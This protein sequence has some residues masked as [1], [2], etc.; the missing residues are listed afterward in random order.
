MDEGLSE[1][2][3]RSR[4]AP[5]SALGR[6]TWRV[7]L[8]HR[9]QR[10]L[11]S[12]TTVLTTLALLVGVGAGL[13][14][15]GFIRLIGLCENLL[16]G[17]L[18]DLLNGMQNYALIVIPVVGALPVGL[19]ITRIASE[20]KG[21]G[22][23]EVMEA[24]ALR[25][26]RIRPVVVVA[27]AVASALCIG[28]GGSVGREGPIVQIGAALGS[29]FGQWF[30]LSDLRM[31]TLVACGA[32]AGIASTFNAPIAGVFFALELILGEFSMGAFG[33]VVLSSV[34]ASVTSRFFLQDHPAFLR[35]P[36]YALV[37]PLV[38]LP[39]Y[40]LLGLLMAAGATAF[41]K[42]LYGMEG[43]F[44]RWSF[45]NWLKPAVGGLLLGLTGL[46]SPSITGGVATH[47][48]VVGKPDVFGSGFGAI[49]AVLTGNL[50]QVAWP[51]VRVLFLLFLFKMAAT[52]FTL[53]SGNSGGIFAP[54]LF[55]GAMLGGAFGEAVHTLWPNLTAPAGAY[56]IVGMAALFAGAARAPL[57]AVL[58]LFELTG[59][60]RIILPLM[61]AVVVSTVFAR[62]LAQESIYTEKLVRRGI[63]WRA[64]RDLNVMEMV[65]VGE[66]MT[67]DLSV[68]PE[69]M[70]ISQLVQELDRTK[71]HGFPVVD[72]NGLLV[73]IVTLQD[74]RRGLEQGKRTVREI[75][76][77]DPLVLF[78]DQTLN[79]A[80]RLFG[81]R[82]V[83][84]I[85][86]VDRANPR[87]LLGVLR[88]ADVVEAYN[89]GL[90]RKLDLEQRVQQVW[91]RS[92]SGTEVFEVELAETSVA[93]GHRLRD[94]PLPPNSV[95]VSIRRGTQVLVPH[96]GTML[97]AGDRVM[98]LSDHAHAVE[99]R[100]RLLRPD[101][102]PERHTRYVEYTIAE[103]APAAGRPIAEVNLGSDC[104]IVSVKR[105]G[106]LLIPHGDTQLLPG[107]RVVVLAHAN[108]L[109]TIARCLEG[110]L[111]G[112]EEGF[113]GV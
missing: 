108:E 23:P 71:H 12:E 34:V 109:E 52:T 88:R 76:T 32:A 75:Y 30:R 16:L 4:P 17:R 7:R 84:R 74:V 92:V 9:L 33:S 72:G 111:G 61:F 15:V 37:N 95:I 89:V 107:D 83:G 27:K 28:S 49:E 97:E 113:L 42:V 66:A 54:S 67:Q 106:E 8:A 10:Y 65:R 105:G 6:G 86:V 58:I 35:V 14:A 63:L 40:L 44:D 46:L 56:A 98:V 20:A 78:P 29:T 43:L 3:D 96:G 99:A 19:V 47:G 100:E 80:M 90:A 57:T 69:H 50:G 39:L 102:H 77:P 18:R 82:G 64:G 62:R 1:R 87:R 2:S 36:E 25:G 104:L 21:H 24:I 85:P 51:A 41:V 112:R 73:G 68:V 38:E 5:G 11:P 70:T 48:G 53:G 103:G 101:L 22:V 93:V 91:M 59:D 94:I 13:G 110:R 79:D 26:G 81:L 31:R 45:P 60:Y 55:M